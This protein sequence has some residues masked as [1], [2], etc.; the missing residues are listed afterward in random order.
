MFLERI[1]EAKE[2]EVEALRE[3]ADELQVRARQAPAPRGFAEALRCADGVAVVAE[4]KRRSPSAGD[5]ASE[6][7][8]GR[9][10]AAYEA[11]GAR[12]V[13]V[14]TDEEHFAGSLADL[15]AARRKTRLPVLRKDF[16]LDPLQV[17]EA[18]AA[19][20]D[21]ILLIA[22]ILS[23]GRLRELIGCVRDLNMDA[24]VEV[25]EE[26]ELGR[27]LEAGATCVGVNARDLSTFEVDL[28]RCERLIRRVPPELVAVAESGVQGP[29]DVERMGAAGADA[30]LVGTALMQGEPG[31]L[32]RS[33][34]DRGAS[35][36]R[37]GPAAARRRG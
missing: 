13:S 10:A 33:L 28:S 30:V 24:L 25:H 22:R 5:L 19:G 6:A 36:V 32:L 27:A 31:A 20:A 3:R 23:D 37:S 14:L 34:V 17:V 1:V 16:A 7:D 18:R 12:A 29:E 21:A 15:R 11:A 35:T 4:F 9:V 26:E 8:P 2:K